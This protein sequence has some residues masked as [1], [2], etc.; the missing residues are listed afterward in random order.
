MYCK[1]CGKE[2]A[3][4][5][6]FCCF[7]GTLQKMPPNNI[8]NSQVVNPH[9]IQNIQGFF[10]FQISKQ[11][12]GFYLLWFLIQ[13][14][15]L[16]VNWNASSSAN[17]YFW[18]FSKG[19]DLNDYDLSEFILYTVVPLIVLIIIN[20]FRKPKEAK[21]YYLQS[22]YDLS[23]E[24]D[25]TPTIIGISLIILSLAITFLTSNSINSYDSVSFMQTRASLSILSLILRVLITIWIVNIARKLN[26][27]TAGWGVF[28]FF[29]P[30]IAL[31]VIG[32]KR[33]LK[34]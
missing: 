33:K 8:S 29:L 11:I 3:E 27:D 32:Q 23:Y 6:R 7:C 5:S 16:L 1:E 25:T 13:L 17:K 12:I 15:L 4:N 21:V 34:K 28:A 30:S 18:F 19:S 22:K 10:G 9:K 24:K 2:I 31:I 14:I 26:R 20:L